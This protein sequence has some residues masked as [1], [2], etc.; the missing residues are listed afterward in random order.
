VD[1]IDSNRS[2]SVPNSIRIVLRLHPC[3]CRKKSVDGIRAVCI[4]K[5]AR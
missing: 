3:Q 1:L 5:S 2:T 4:S